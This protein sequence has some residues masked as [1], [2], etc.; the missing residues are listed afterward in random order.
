M[1]GLR[2]NIGENGLHDLTIPCEIKQLGRVMCE[3][4]QD[5]FWLLVQALRERPDGVAPQ[6][7]A[8]DL[9]QVAIH[10]LPLSRTHLTAH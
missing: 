7:V 10:G 5:V 4:L 9:H 2:K 1:P 6:E 8:Q 3:H